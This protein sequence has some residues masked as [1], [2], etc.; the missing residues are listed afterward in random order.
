MD[1]ILSDSRALMVRQVK[2]WGEILVG[3]ETRNRF[4]IF[5]DEGRLIGRAAEEAGG[6]G[7]VLSRNFFGKCRPSTIHVYDA[8]GQEVATGRKP[9]RFYFHRMG[10]YEGSKL[11]GAIQR[12]FSIFH[13]LF[14]LEDETGQELL[15]I[16]SPW[17]RIWTF[18]LLADETEVGRISKRWGGALKEMFT[19]ADSFRVEFSHPKLPL[20]AKKLLLAGVFLIDFTCFENNVRNR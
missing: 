3:F 1:Q 6:V 11:V 20:A 15:R 16:K 12:R 2:E 19:D 10:L 9:F 18:K 7:A 13:R 4:E 5:D 17:F 14:S 8:E